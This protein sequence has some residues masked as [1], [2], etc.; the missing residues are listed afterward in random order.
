MLSK[1]KL[2]KA[3]KE[4]TSGRNSLADKQSEG[5]DQRDEK[6]KEMLDNGRNPYVKHYMKNAKLEKL[7]KYLKGK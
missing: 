7:K 3:L 4:A 6:I 5:N 2:E 1:E